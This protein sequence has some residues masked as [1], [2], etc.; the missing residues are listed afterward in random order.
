MRFRILML[1]IAAAATLFAAPASAGPG[2]DSSVYII[3][4]INGTDLGLD[5]ALAVDISVNGACALTG[6]TFKTVAGPVSLPAG[7]YDIAISLASAGDPC[8]NPPVIEAS[9]SVAAG[10][11]ATIIAHLNAAGAPTASKFTNDLSRPG[12]FRSRISLHHAAAAPAVDV[13]ARRFFWFFFLSGIT[14]E[15][16]ANGQQASTAVPFGIYDIDVNVANTTTT[17]LE[18]KRFFYPG[19]TYLVYVVGSAANGT[20]DTIEIPVYRRWG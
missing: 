6:V 10:E 18:A 9:V 3:H 7:D 2:D 4:G 14:V 8:S 16:L 20:L 13:I 19:A 15:D 12:F 5:E 1:M 11:N 17:V